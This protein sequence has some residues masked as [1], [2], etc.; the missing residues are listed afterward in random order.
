M[1]RH[2][3]YISPIG[4]TFFLLLLL[5]VALKYILLD[6]RALALCLLKKSFVIYS[7]VLF[8]VAM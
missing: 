5:Y 1:K 2:S 6:E 3:M 4:S 8:V 7:F